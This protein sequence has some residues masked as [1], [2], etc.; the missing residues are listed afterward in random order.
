MEL[1]KRIIK[2]IEAQAKEMYE[3]KNRQSRGVANIPAQG[4]TIRIRIDF[5]Q[6]EVTS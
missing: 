2:S 6:E 1:L 5:Y 3:G 4:G